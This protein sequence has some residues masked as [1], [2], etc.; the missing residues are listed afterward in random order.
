MATSANERNPAIVT[1]R[2]F[3]KSYGKANVGLQ[4]VIEGAVH[5]MVNR[6]RA[7][8][9]TFSM[10]YARVQSLK[11][12]DVL[13]VDVSGPHRMLAIW[14]SELLRLLAVGDHDVVPLY[15]DG[16]LKVDVHQEYDAPSSF[17][18]EGPSHGLR[19]FSSNP[20]Q[21]YAEYGPEQHAE[22]FYYLSSEQEEL[23]EDITLDV[24]EKLEAGF[25]PKSSMI[26][27]GPGTGKT[28]V[29]I[30]L[31][32]E[33]NQF[34]HTVRL[35]AGKSVLEQIAVSLPDLDLDQFVWAHSKADVVD[36]LLVDD[37][38]GYQEVDE[39]LTR[40]RNANINAVIIAFD[41][42]Q[43][44]ET[45]GRWGFTDDCFSELCE[46]HNAVPYDLSECYRQKE[47]VGRAV[48]KMLVT[49]SE[50]TPFLAE[51]KIQDFS[52]AHV[53]VTQIA[54]NMSFPNKH[55][56]SFVHF[57]ATKDNYVAELKRIQE[58]P[59]W[60]HWPPLLIA[61]DADMKNVD[62]VCEWIDGFSTPVKKVIVRA[63]DFQS[64]KG[65]EY[66]HTFLF[67]S[68]ELY[69]QLENSFQGSGRSLYAKRRL[70]RIPFSRAKDS[71]VTFVM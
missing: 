66:Q 60:A 33:L 17:W 11:R 9:N 54:N 28:V 53:G 7:D 6:I 64:I 27:G 67:I 19:F 34:G 8:K 63:D 23:V 44:D 35:V 26:I 42:C 49:I 32:K 13:E 48:N 2:R 62:E 4:G 57:P 16:K 20:C 38:S 39:Y 56:Y 22:W 15:D 31:L 29:L 68:S 50:S 25:R 69:N 30:R 14:E 61:I 10:H 45:G 1:S 3:Q 43:L 71:M 55:G 18:P 5:D 40:S 12:S 47:N 46:Q 24:N 59:T 21:T 58:R 52:Q 41:P 70:L 51:S 36:V 37:P 65:L